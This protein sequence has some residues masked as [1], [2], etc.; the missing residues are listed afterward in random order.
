PARVVV[1]AHPNQ[2][3]E[4]EVL[5][6]EPQAILEQNVTRFAVLIRL[7]NRADLLK[8]GM[9]AEVEIRVE[10][11]EDVPT[12]PTMALRTASD[13]PAT[14]VMLGIDEAELRRQLSA[15]RS[16]HAPGMNGETSASGDRSVQ[17]PDGVDSN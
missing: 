4:G 10:N 1:A 13:I 14:A 7:E 6:I 16:P 12:V 2:P 17:I 8:P 9:N 11:R 3:F 5:K 15:D